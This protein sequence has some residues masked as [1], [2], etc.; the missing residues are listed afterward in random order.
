MEGSVPNGNQNTVQRVRA[1]R[2]HAV[3]WSR[4]GMRGAFHIVAVADLSSHLG[5]SGAGL[6]YAAAALPRC[7]M[8]SLF[9]ARS[10]AVYRLCRHLIGAAMTVRVPVQI[11]TRIGMLMSHARR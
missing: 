5:A 8:L 6:G 11:A 10:G 2:S 4:R 3:A 9:I 1:K 7:E